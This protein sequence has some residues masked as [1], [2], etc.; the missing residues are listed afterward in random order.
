[1]KKEKLRPC[2]CIDEYTAQKLNEQGIGHND[3]SITVT[4]G[5]VVLEMGHT[6]IKVGRRRFKQFAE[7]FLEEQTLKDK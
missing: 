3:Q 6:T 2:D 1:M 4:N 7:W 5:R